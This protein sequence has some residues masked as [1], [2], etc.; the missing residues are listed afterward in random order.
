MIEIKVLLVNYADG[1]LIRELLRKGYAITTVN[2]KGKLFNSITDK[3][4]LIYFANFTPHRWADIQILLHKENIPIVYGFHAPSIIFKPYRATNHFNNIISVANLARMKTNRS[5]LALH[6][7]NTDE[8]K[9]LRF[10]GLN[11]NYVPL[12]VDTNLF[13]PSSKNSRFTIVFVSPRYQ[14]GVDML[15]SIVPAVLKKAP[16]VKFILTGIGFLSNYFHSLKKAYRNNVEVCERLPG[17]QFTQLFSSSHVLL[18]P[19]RFES[20]GLVVL[21]ALS[22]GMPVVCFDIAG[23]PRDTVKRHCVGVVAK[24]FNL[25]EI[26]NG[27]LKYHRMWLDDIEAFE[28]LSSFCRVTALKYDWSVSSGLFDIMFKK[29]LEQK[30]TKV[31]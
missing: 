1:S 31:R 6:V 7:L 21:E 16:D 9:L 10:L 27:I 26:V 8:F 2:T 17:N 14:K 18:F 24:S 11:C 25:D 12:G 28:N 5:V 22:S 23:T 20:F 30:L 3:F 4:D 15:I 19:S 29:V 13:R